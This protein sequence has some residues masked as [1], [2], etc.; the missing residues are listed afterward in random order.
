ME[1]NGQLRVLSLFPWQ[2]RAPVPVEEDAAW[3][4]GV[5]LNDLEKGTRIVQLIAWTV[6]RERGV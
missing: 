4:L 3:G 2:K 6:L 5:V 1:A